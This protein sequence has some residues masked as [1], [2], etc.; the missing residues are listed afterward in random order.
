MEG[1]QGNADA[2]FVMAD[3]VFVSICLGQLNPQIA[4]LQGKMKIR[5]SMAK[6]TKFTPDLFPAISA[7]MLSLDTPEAV[8]QFLKTLE[9]ST[10]AGAGS[11]DNELSPNASK[12]TSAQLFPLMKEH[13]KSPAGANLVKQVRMQRYTF[14]ASR[15]Y[16]RLQEHVVLSSAHFRSKHGVESSFFTSGRLCV[17]R[18]PNPNDR[19]ARLDSLH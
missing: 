1:L 16:S 12:L 3:E 5:G 6:A 8:K 15:L 9:P 7:E 2:T 11:S 10:S 13:L 19:R 17:P 4:F 14:A 18:G